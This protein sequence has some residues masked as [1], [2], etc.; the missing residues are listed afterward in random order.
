[1]SKFIPLLITFC[2][3]L[4]LLGC[5]TKPTAPGVCGTIRGLSCPEQQYCDFGVGQCKVADAPG[6][7]K[8]R[9]SNCTM[10][11]DPVCGCDG[12][13]Y[14]NACAAATAGVSVDHTGECTPPKP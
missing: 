1:M 3:T 7:C 14:S 11:F 6:T 4:A 12:K 10:Q 2:A 13:S 9:P 8:T 5:S